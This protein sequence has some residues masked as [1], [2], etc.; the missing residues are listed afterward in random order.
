M[1]KVIS[2]TEINEA[3]DHRYLRV[4]DLPIH[5]FG[6]KTAASTQK[7]IWPNFRH[8]VSLVLL[9]LTR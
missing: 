5:H 2:A 1:K 8:F 9:E 7:N 6:A 4:L 3:L